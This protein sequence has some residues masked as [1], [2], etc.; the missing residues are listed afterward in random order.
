MPGVGGKVAVKTAGPQFGQDGDLGTGFGQFPQAG[1]NP[2]GIFGY[3]T[4]KNIKL[5]NTGMEV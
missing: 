4:G 2:F 5:D 1:L 3:F